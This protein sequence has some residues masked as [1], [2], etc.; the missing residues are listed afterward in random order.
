MPRN[1]TPALNNINPS[2]ICP[3]AMLLVRDSD[4][5]CQATENAYKTNAIVNTAIAE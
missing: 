1:I 3:L 4:F 5:F 2:I